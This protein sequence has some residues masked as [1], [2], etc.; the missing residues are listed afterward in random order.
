MRQVHGADVR[1]VMEPFGDSPPP[2]DG[3]CTDRAGPA[4]TVFVADC[5]P[6]LLAD[7]VAGVVGCAHAGRTGLAAR[8]VTATVREMTRRGADPTRTTALVGPMVCASCYEVPR[9]MRDEM[10]A[11]HPAASAVTSKGTRS[12]DLR[13]AVLGQLLDCGVTDVRHDHRCTVESPELFSY[14]REGPTGDFAGY[15]WLDPTPLL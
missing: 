7:P 5:A 14:R 10:A 6:V 2:T 12:I 8:V 4:L 3:I 15:V 13:A 9:A 1:W 11:L